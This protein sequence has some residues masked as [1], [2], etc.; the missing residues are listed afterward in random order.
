MGSR[1]ACPFVEAAAERCDPAA[2]GKVEGG[3]TCI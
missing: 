3:C 2:A 1:A